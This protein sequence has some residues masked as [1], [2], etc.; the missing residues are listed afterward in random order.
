MLNAGMS[1]A[2]LKE[3]LG[4]KS[5]RMTAIYAKVHLQTVIDEYVKASKV[6]H[7]K[8]VRPNIALEKKDDPGLNLSNVILAIRKKMETRTAKE[9]H[10]L[11]LIA[12][13]LKRI[14]DDL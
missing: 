1:M 14:Q 4:H 9:R 13:R 3:I 6:Y 5:F 11:N 8:F 7:Q 2:A 12:R 10:E